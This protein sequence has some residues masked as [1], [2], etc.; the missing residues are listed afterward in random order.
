[1][2]GKRVFAVVAFAL[3][4]ILIFGMKDAGAEGYFS[5]VTQ[6]RYEGWACNPATPN[7]AGWLHFWRDDGKFLGALHAGIQREQAVGN[8]CGDSGQHGF[9]GDLQF[10]ADYLDNKKHTVRAYFI[11]A[12]NTSFELQNAIVVNFV[13]GSQPYQFNTITGD[14]CQ[15]VDPF[16]NASGWLL[17]QRPSTDVVRCG[18]YWNIPPTHVYVGDANAPVGSTLE[19]CGTK[20][21]TNKLPQGWQIIST[22]SNSSCV[23]R[24]ST[25]Q[26]GSYPPEHTFYYFNTI[27]IKKIY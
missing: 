7:Y 19:V 24:I 3:K 5:A 22:Q 23:A 9:H 6:Y 17:K 20:E 25:Y 14:A 2:C 13:G 18:S 12:D 1:M 10:S 26:Y 15:A 16:I 11:N 21:N 27:R 4:L 8:I